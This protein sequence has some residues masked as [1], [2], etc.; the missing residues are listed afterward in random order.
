MGLSWK[1]GAVAVMVGAL[2]TTSFT[3]CARFYDS[4]EVSIED[5]NQYYTYETGVVT[6]VKSVVLKDEDN[7]GALLG[8]G[9]GLVLGSMVGRSKGNTL[10]MLLGALGGA[11]VGHYAGKGNGQELGVRLKDGRE[12]VILVKTSH[13]TFH[14]GDRIRIIKDGSRIVRVEKM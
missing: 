3:G 2:L 14:P 8:G 7:S 13:E 5:T 6:Y 1:K 11:L 9:T 12:V 10:A 4:N